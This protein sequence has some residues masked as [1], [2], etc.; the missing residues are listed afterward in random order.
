[1]DLMPRCLTTD[2]ISDECQLNRAL[3]LMTLCTLSAARASTNVS[4][5]PAVLVRGEAPGAQV[6]I[7]Q[8]LGKHLRGKLGRQ[9]AVEYAAARHRLGQPGRVADG[10][11][12]I[13]K[14][15]LDRPDREQSA[16]RLADA[17]AQ[18]RGD[19]GSREEPAKIGPGV[20]A[21]KH[22]RLEPRLLLSHHRHEP[23][24]PLGRHAPSDVDLEPFGRDRI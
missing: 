16:D 5:S 12:A 19:L 6:V 23:G 7:T 4:L 8:G 2:R 21:Q 9:Q 13:P 1:M 15:A 14:G 24:E 18:A 10:H 3:R 20:P 17:I 22:P 11:D